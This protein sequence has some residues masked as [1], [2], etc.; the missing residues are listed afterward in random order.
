MSVAQRLAAQNL[1]H[2]WKKGQSGNPAGRSKLPEHLKAIKAFTAEE[3]SR[4]IS[5]YGRM[6]LLDLEIV[7]DNPDSAI[8]DRIFAKMFCDTFE[9]GSYATLTFLLDR[10]IGKV[11]DVVY[12]EPEDSPEKEELR[13]MPIQELLQLV[14][15]AIPE[16]L[17]NAHP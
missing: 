16:E 11:P 13:K 7:K 3:I 15:K 14:R 5:K 12:T 17:P 9:K 1:P 8:M 6:T 4:M 10:C 2:L